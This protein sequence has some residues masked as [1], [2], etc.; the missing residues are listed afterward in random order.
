MHHCSIFQL[1]HQPSKWQSGLEDSNSRN[2]ITGSSVPVRN[3][4]PPH[5]W[6]S[7]Y[8]LWFIPLWLN[9]FQS[10]ECQVII[11]YM[12]I[13]NDWGTV[14]LRRLGMMYEAFHFYALYHTVTDD[15]W[16]LLPSYSCSLCHVKWVAGVSGQLFMDKWPP[17][18]K[19]TR[20]SLC[21]EFQQRG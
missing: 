9:S 21:Y 10:H 15:D 13:E 7:P 18:N 5:K 6:Q 16:K 11:S 1:M 17:K 20:N 14:W 19:Q 8:K 3:R 12:Y 2:S 4:I